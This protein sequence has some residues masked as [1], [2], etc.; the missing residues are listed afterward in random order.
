MKILMI[1]CLL[2]CGALAPAQQLMHTKVNIRFDYAASRLYGQ[3]WISVTASDSVVLDAK[4]MDIHRVSRNGK[5]LQFRYDSLRLFVPL[6]HQRAVYTI[7]VDYTAKPYERKGIGK[8]ERGLYF[9][10]SSSPQIWTEGEPESTS[11]WLPTLD[12]P[13]QK[14]TTELSMTVPGAYTTL[15]NGRLSAQ[16]SHANGTRT[17]TWIMDRPNAPYLTMMA[18]GNFH[19]THDHWRD[20]PVDYYLEPQYAPYA[21]QLF[22]LTPAAMEFFSRITGVPFPWNKEAEIVVHEYVSGAMENTTATVFG[23]P[24]R[25]SIRELADRYD[26]PGVAHELF[27]QWFGDYVTCKSWGD[28]TLNESFAD[29]GEILWV[30]HQYGSD[31]AGN[32]IQA[33]LDNYLGDS[34]NFSL[35]LVNYHFKKAEDMSNAVTYKKGGRILWMLRNYMG[36]AAFNKG[37]HL[38]L[39]RHAYGNATSAQLCLAMQEACGRDLQWFFD[40]WYYGSGHPVLDISYQYANGTQTVIVKQTQPIPFKLPVA[41]DLYVHGRKTRHTITL[42]KATDTLRFH[43]M[44]PDLV[45]VDADKV[46]VAQKTDHH[47]AEEFAF[48]YAHTPLYL[49]RYEALDYFCNHPQS[50]LAKTIIGLA[51]KDRYFGLRVKAVQATSDGEAV[52]SLL[53]METNNQV[54]AAALQQLGDSK[55]GT[56]MGLYTRALNSRSFIVQAKALTGMNTV[57]TAKAMVAARKLE[58]DN[59]GELTSAIFELYAASGSKANWAFVYR[60]YTTGTLSEKINLLPQFAAMTASVQDPASAQQ[61]VAVLKQMGVQFKSKGAAPMIIKLLEEVRAAR[62]TQHDHATISLIIEAESALHD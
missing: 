33:G 14:G 26:D 48:M 53:Q 32:R 18:V 38:Y 4:G 62:L 42:S 20:V 36:P 52:D 51:L 29:L 39:T 12:R 3:E 7:Y 28:L 31:A 60:R 1:A 41:I 46:L 55:A 47:S 24:F 6:P 9:V 59:Y 45:N 35:P 44:Q 34:S 43:T 15:S 17:D 37:M 50:P 25:A 23:E 56:A 13:D 54:I 30:E 2:L 22:G 11:G 19:I 16:K 49:D 40:Q 8:R 58:N 57:D 21:R 10:Q 27:H 5:D 61:G